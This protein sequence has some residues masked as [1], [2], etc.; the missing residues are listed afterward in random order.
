M[1]AFKPEDLWRWS[2]VFFQHT[3]ILAM[4]HHTNM[5][6][7]LLIVEDQNLTEGP[8]TKD[9]VLVLPKTSI[10]GTTV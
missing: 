8:G 2:F 9:I 4:R 1:Y 3:L 10:S 6:L 7:S 5:Q